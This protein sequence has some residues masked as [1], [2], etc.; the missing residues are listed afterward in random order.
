[1][2]YQYE[3]LNLIVSI[4]IYMYA[5]FCM[6]KD[7]CFCCDVLLYISSRMHVKTLTCGNGDLL[8]VRPTL[9][10]R[11]RSQI[12][13]DLIGTDASLLQLSHLHKRIKEKKVKVGTEIPG[14]KAGHKALN[15]VTHYSVLAM[16]SVEQEYLLIQHAQ[17]LHKVAQR[18][19]FPIWLR[20]SAL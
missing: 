1:M 8:H 13:C 15:K 20:A 11:H 19:D 17:G 4:H 7:G 2:L 12:D 16:F 14:Q 9:F 6:W 18:E 10:F 5:R 3:M